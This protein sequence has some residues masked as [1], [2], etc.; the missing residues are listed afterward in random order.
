MIKAPAD[1]ILS[2]TDGRAE[3]L[4]GK[5]IRTGDKIFEILGGEGTIAEILVSE[6][7]GSVLYKDMSVELFLYTA[8]EK[9]IPVKILDVSHYPEL[10][11]QKMYCYKIRT[12]LPEDK[13]DL[14]LGMRGIAKISGGNVSLGYYLFKSIVLYFR[15]L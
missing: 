5:S 4:A 14:R 9:A 11:E 12:E 3:L 7:D 6:R 2:L 10:T 13:K 8:P 1:G 15:G